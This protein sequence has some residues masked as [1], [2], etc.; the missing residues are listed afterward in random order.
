M[1]FWQAGPHFAADRYTYLACLP[2]AGLAAGALA[3]WGRSPKAAAGAAAVLLALGVLTFRQTG[4]WKDSFTLWDHALRIDTSAALPFYNRGLARATK[5]D[6]DG[7]I[8]D[9]G[10]AI[11]RNPRHVDAYVNRGIAHRNRKDLPA[12]FA[13]YDAA[14]AVNPRSPETLVNRATVRLAR[15]DADGAASD[16]REALQ[17]APPDWPHRKTARDLWEEAHRKQGPRRTRP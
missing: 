10:E 14:L 5:G 4:F 15:G 1:A 3:R 2:W 8:G 11:A 12:A 13:D 7:A 9:Y 6:L 16:C 17:L